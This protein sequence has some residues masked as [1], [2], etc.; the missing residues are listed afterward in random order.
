MLKKGYAFYIY[1]IATGC[2]KDIA[3]SSSVVFSE[4]LHCV[5]VA[6]SSE[7]YELYPN[8]LVYF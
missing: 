2:S 6:Y 3:L 5:A 1:R 8:T 7:L 4:T